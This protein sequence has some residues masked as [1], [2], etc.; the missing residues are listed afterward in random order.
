VPANQPE[1]SIVA[2]VTTYSRKRSSS[3]STVSGSATKSV[4]PARSARCA[5]SITCVLT[6]ATTAATSAAAAQPTAT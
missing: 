6:T 1:A 3:G 4:A 5:A 2:C